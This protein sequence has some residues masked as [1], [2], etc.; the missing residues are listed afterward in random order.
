[1][2]DYGRTEIAVNYRMK[3]TKKNKAA[4]VDL[5]LLKTLSFGQKKKRENSN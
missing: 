1:M 4:N 5:S 2:S 3:R